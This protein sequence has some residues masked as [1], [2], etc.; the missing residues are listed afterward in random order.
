MTILYVSYI[1]LFR[2]VIEIENIYYLL[3][4]SLL[5]YAS[6]YIYSFIY[7]AHYYDIIFF[8][9]NR[10]TEMNIAKKKR[11]KIR[12]KFF[13]EIDLNAIYCIMIYI[14][15]YFRCIRLY[16]CIFSCAIIRYDVF[17]IFYFVYVCRMIMRI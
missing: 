7:N 1:I 8:H 2:N 5:C 12:T 16:I 9:A 15:S 13:R 6:T 10:T 4:L 14:F 3:M 17:I 11:K